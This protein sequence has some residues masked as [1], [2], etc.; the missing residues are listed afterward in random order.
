ME[1]LKN[2]IN[3][4]DWLME[5]PTLE[6]ARKKLGFISERIKLMPK[7]HPSEE[8]FHSTYNLIAEYVRSAE[9]FIEYEEKKEELST[10][11]FRD[12]CHLFESKQSHFKRIND[13]NKKK[14]V[15]EQLKAE[16][17]ALDI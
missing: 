11:S 9:A 7:G 17:T 2:L 3:C 6:E 16:L 8:D 15:F 13:S 10:R 1:T 4:R 12:D 14:A 5:N